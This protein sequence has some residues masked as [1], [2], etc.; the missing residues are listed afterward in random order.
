[1][2]DALILFYIKEQQYKHIFMY[3]YCRSSFF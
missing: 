3:L 1:M 2:L